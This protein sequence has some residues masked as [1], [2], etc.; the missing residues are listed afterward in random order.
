MPRT[1]YHLAIYRLDNA[2]VYSA[3]NKSLREA[4]RLAGLHVAE[5]DNYQRVVRELNRVPGMYAASFRLQPPEGSPAKEQSPCFVIL[6]SATLVGS[7]FTFPPV[8][9]GPPSSGS[10]S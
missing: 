8:F 4:V 1:L 2:L 10:T 7:D 9:G 5:M 6:N 3:S